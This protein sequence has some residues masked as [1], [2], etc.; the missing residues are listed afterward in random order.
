MGDYVRKSGKLWKLRVPGRCIAPK[1]HPRESKPFLH[2]NQ[3]EKEPVHDARAQ[4]RVPSSAEDRDD[5]L[6]HLSRRL[7]IEEEIA[8]FRRI[9]SDDE[10]AECFVASLLASRKGR[11]AA[12]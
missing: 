6:K 9:E 5:C 10:S 7:R 8:K 1:P 11:E 3:N 12:R 4:S 2:R